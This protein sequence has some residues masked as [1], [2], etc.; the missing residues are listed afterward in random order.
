LA[1]LFGVRD[2]AELKTVLAHRL[3]DR[4]HFVEHEH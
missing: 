1:Y 3:H 4:R 2:L